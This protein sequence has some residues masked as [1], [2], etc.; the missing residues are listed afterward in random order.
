MS[1]HYKNRHLPL[2]PFS[3]GKSSEPCDFARGENLYVYKQEGQRSNEIPDLFFYKA[4]IHQEAV[5]FV[6]KAKSLNL[7]VMLKGLAASGK[8]TV[9]P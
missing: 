5:C 9:K 4:F 7:H 1:I 3:S 2:S 6:Y 8:Y